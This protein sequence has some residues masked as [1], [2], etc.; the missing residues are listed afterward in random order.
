MGPQ[1][2]PDAP[3]L[4]GRPGADVAGAPGV[5]KFTE[6]GRTLYTNVAGDNAAKLGKRELGIGGN[7]GS[8]RRL[9]DQLAF[10]HSIDLSRGRSVGV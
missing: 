6:N 8:G 7:F 10:T 4:R 1:I 9:G 2:N 3:S 5:G